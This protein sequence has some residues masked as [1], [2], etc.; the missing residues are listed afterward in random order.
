[1]GGVSSRPDEQNEDQNCNF[2]MTFCPRSSPGHPTNKRGI[3]DPIGSP[4]P[5]TPGNANRRRM[6]E[7]YE[8]LER[9]E[10]SAGDMR[11]AKFGDGTAAFRAT[12]GW[13]G[14]TM[15]DTVYDGMKKNGE[16]ELF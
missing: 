11:S 16:Q 12:N 10:E 8:G 13:N 2:G 6:R 7:L 15:N 1:M 3:F 4:L 5:D 14:N 9:E